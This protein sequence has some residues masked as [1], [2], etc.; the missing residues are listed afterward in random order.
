MLWPEL[1]WVPLS[2]L[3]L[4]ELTSFHCILKSKRSSVTKNKVAKDAVIVG[5]VGFLSVKFD[6]GEKHEK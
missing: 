4:A 6:L 3:L 1:K 5:M 2:V